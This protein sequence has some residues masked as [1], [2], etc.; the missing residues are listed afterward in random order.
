M[1]IVCKY[2]L[3]LTMLPFHSVE[4]IVA[5]QSLFFL[6]SRSP[7]CLVFSF[8]ALAS[9]VKSQNSSQDCDPNILM[10]LAFGSVQQSQGQQKGLLHTPCKSREVRGSLRDVSASCSQA[11]VVIK[12][13]ND[14]QHTSGPHARKNVLKT[15]CEPY[16]DR[17]KY[18][19]WQHGP[20]T[21]WA[22]AEPNP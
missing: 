19:T 5:V 11:P 6:V 21:W 20:R 15:W 13:T 12:P 22:H 4:D 18:S 17:I 7:T 14:V 3:P 8:V 1:Y 9:G 16:L 2:F 10:G